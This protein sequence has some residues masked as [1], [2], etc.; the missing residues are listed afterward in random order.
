MT[1]LNQPIQ[2]FEDRIDVHAYN[3]F[4]LVHPGY[5]TQCI[6]LMTLIQKHMDCEPGKL[7]RC[8]DVGTGPGA[9]LQMLM[10]MLPNLDVVAIEPSPVAYQYLQQN[11]GKHRHLKTL[12]IDFLNFKP[13][14]LFPMVMSV[15]ASHHLNTYFFLNKVYDCLEQNGKL[16]IADEMICPYH[17]V[18]ERQRNLIL[19]HTA[20]MLAVMIPIPEAVRDK[21]GIKE[22]RLVYELEINVPIIVA[23]TLENRIQ[24]AAYKCRELW[25]TMEDLDLGTSISHEF[26]A[27]YR[28]QVLELQALVAGLDYQVEQKT[29]AEQFI[30]L[31]SA[32]GLRLLEHERVYPTIGLRDMDAGTHVFAFEKR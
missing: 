5:A 25:R 3:W 32:A 18:Q 17:N 4:E 26:M 15:G 16:F 12:N 10:E 23:D 9:P 8:I 27:F 19:H 20:Y 2:V 31:A 29:F 14:L 28:L 6:A 13:D 30:K 21:L 1:R 24:E 11:M 22:R 7:I